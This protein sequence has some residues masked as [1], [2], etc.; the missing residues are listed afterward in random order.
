MKEKKIEIG[1]L[2]KNK[3]EALGYTM[4]QL[5]RMSGVDKA[6]ISR[7]EKMERKNP[8]PITLKN[9]AKA[10]NLDIIAI[11]REIGIL[12]KTNDSFIEE[13][14]EIL[15]NEGIKEMLELYLKDIS[16]KAMIQGKTEEVKEI[17]QGLENIRKKL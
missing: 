13:L 12:D 10:L 16:Y 4:G 2:I 15:D 3:R 7:I 11:Y 8:N 9:L 14:T 1:E 5:S 17:V 6:E